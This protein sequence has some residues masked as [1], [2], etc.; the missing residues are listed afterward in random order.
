MLYLKPPQP[1]ATSDSLPVTSD[2]LQEVASSVS[3]VSPELTT[4]DYFIETIAQ[5]EMKIYPNPTTENITLIMNR[6]PKKI[7]QCAAII[8]FLHILMMNI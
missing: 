8:L 6:K 7:F 1:P 3:F 2:E 4:P 5:V